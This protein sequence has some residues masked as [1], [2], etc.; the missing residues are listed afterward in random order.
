MKV[1]KSS[2]K[3]ILPT[4]IVSNI[5]RNKRLDMTST[6]VDHQRPRYRKDFIPLLTDTGNRIGQRSFN[7]VMLKDTGSIPE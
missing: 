2:V 1:K 4:M 3:R 5:Q 6:F 7:K